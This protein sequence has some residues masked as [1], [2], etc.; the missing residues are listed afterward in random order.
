MK[1]E[2]ILG[3]IFI[4]MLLFMALPVASADID[5]TGIGTQ[6]DGLD[7]YGYVD[8]RNIANGNASGAILVFIDGT[9]VAAEILNMPIRYVAG[10]RC[11]PAKTLEFPLNDTEGVH[12][13]LAYAFSQNV[14]TQRSYGYYAEDW[15]M[16]Q[17]DEVEEEVEVWLECP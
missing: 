3:G 4:L 7:H 9:I 1:K 12:T 13:I 15:W 17:E 8:Y 16:D 2:L 11:S 5:I 14:S 6:Y 10:F